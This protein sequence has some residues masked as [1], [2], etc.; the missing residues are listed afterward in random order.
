MNEIFSILFENEDNVN[1]DIINTESFQCGEDDS[2]APEWTAWPA[3]VAWPAW[4]AWDAD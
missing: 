1:V 2:T 3:W 4:T